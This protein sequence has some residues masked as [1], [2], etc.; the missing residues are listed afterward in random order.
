MYHIMLNYQV[1]IRFLAIKC[2]SYVFDF[3]RLFVP[4]ILWM[5]QKNFRGEGY[6][7]RNKLRSWI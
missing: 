7:K 6:V 4:I 2:F 3:D 5:I 1:A